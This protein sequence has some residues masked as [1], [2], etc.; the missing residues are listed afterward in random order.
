MRVRH[1]RFSRPLA[2][3]VSEVCTIRRDDSG[4]IEV[5]GERAFVFLWTFRRGMRY[6]RMTFRFTWFQAIWLWYR[7][8]VGSV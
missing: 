7:L 1:H 4:L 5:G 3:E 8:I 6:F 2:P